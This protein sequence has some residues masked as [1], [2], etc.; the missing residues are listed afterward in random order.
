MNETILVFD[1]AGNEIF[2]WT[3]E[4][5]K[6]RALCERA[7]RRSLLSVLPQR[8]AAFMEDFLLG[9]ETKAYLG[10]GP[11]SFTGL[12]SG[13]SFVCAFLYARGIFEVRCVSSLDIRAARTT[14]AFG[15]TFLTIL[16]F[17]EEELFAAI[18]RW[19][20]DSMA[21]IIPPTIVPAN[22]LG[23]FVS[24]SG[25]APD[26]VVADEDLPPAIDRVIA[27]SFPS[28]PRSAPGK[29]LANAFLSHIPV[30]AVVDVRHDP[31]R[32]RYLATPAALQ[33]DDTAHY[34]SPFDGD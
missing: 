18:V 1:S 2:L 16:P 30:L 6:E 5:E 23:T 33:G 32:L 4:N 19:E 22:E 13:I 15:K 29:N 7:P 10:I 8:F 21:T 31:L 25:V 28:L 17:H 20:N 12:K 27:D 26:L 11:G 14:A 3:Y 24:R 34:V 9:S